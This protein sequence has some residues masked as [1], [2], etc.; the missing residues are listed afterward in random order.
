MDKPTLLFAD[1]S[2]VYFVLM[3]FSWEGRWELKEKVAFLIPED[4]DDW[5]YKATVDLLNKYGTKPDI[6][7]IGKGPGSF[8]GLKV[9]FAFMRTWALLSNTPLFPLSSLW[10]WYHVFC[11][12]EKEPLLVRTNRSLYLGQ[13][14][15]RYLGA[16]PL[17]EWG[18]EFSKAF[19]F[20][21]AWRGHSRFPIDYK[22]FPNFEEVHLTIEKLIP[23][24]L[25]SLHEILD[26][27]EKYHWSL[28]LP[29]YG[30]ELSYLAKERKMVF[31]HERE[32]K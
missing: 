2:T 19:V 8:T 10:F 16:K 31:H 5:F 6:L 14:Q 26:N 1:S 3:L 4:R 28:A 17:A 25:P 11:A 24:P 30:F 7:A 29:H 27:K 12:Q 9:G 13:Q 32:K 15:D 21:S 20:G 22:D 23:P 18:K